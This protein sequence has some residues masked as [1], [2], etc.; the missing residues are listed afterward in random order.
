[1]GLGILQTP[2]HFAGLLVLPAGGLVIERFGF[3]AGFL[4][5][6]ALYAGFLWLSHRELVVGK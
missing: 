1:M 6:A 4:L 3:G 2:L 5:G